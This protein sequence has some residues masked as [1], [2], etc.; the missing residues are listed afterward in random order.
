VGLSV[1]DA[2][3][4]HL[5]AIAAI[6]ARAADESHATFDLEGPPVEWWRE[7]GE[8]DELLA[9]VEDG[10]VVGFAKSGS[11]KARPAYDSTRETSAYVHTDH[12]GKGVGNALYTELL[13]RLDATEGLRLAVGGVT[14]PNP[15]SDALHASHG[16]TVVGTFEDVGVKLGRGW[17]VRWYQRP[18]SGGASSSPS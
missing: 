17:S 2:A 9:A 11:F 1:V 3:E 13:R 10:M 4:E 16:F 8:T 6:Y 5:P 14:Q 12:R 18:L 7:V 15:A